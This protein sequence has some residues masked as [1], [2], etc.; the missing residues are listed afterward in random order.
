MLEASAAPPVRTQDRE[1]VGALAAIGLT[2]GLALAGFLLAGWRGTPPPL[3]VVGLVSLLFCGVITSLVV[4]MAFRV[5]VRQGWPRMARGARWASTVAALMNVVFWFV[6]FVM[7]RRRL[8]PAPT[9][10]VSVLASSRPRRG[11]ENLQRRP[12]PAAVS[13]VRPE[14]E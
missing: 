8:S 7:A 10:M 3:V 11:A 5:L 13:K 2:C 14:R 6:A 4:A 1:W 9:T 12:A